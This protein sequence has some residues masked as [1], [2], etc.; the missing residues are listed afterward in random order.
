MY[1]S[2]FSIHW[3]EF[4]VSPCGLVIFSR[5]AACRCFTTRLCLELFLRA[6]DRQGLPGGKDS[7]NV[8][9]DWPR[10]FRF[11]SAHRIPAWTLGYFCPHAAV[12]ENLQQHRMAYPA[13]DDVGFPGPFIQGI[14]AALHLGDHPAGY[15]PVID[16]AGN[17]GQ[18]YAADE[19][20]VLP[21]DPGYIGQ[22]HQ[23]FG[24]ESSRNFACNQVG[25]DVVTLPVHAHP[26][27]G[28]DRQELAVLQGL[29]QL[30]VHLDHI[31]YEADVDH[32]NAAVVVFYLLQHLFAE[33]K[34]AVLA[35]KPDCPAAMLVQVA[36]HL[37]VD[38]TGQHHLDYGHGL[39]VRNPPPPDELGNDA[40]ALQGLVYLRTPAVDHD[41]VDAERAEQHHIES[42]RLLQR[43]IGHGVPAVLDDD[44]LAGESPD[45]RECLHQR[46][47]L[48]D[49]LLH[50]LPQ[51]LKYDGKVHDYSKKMQIINAGEGFREDL[52]QI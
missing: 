11:A 37:L 15:R 16:Q 8:S 45:V 46:V 39:L 40:V 43:F 42:K 41:H 3:A 51:I 20:V 6:P 7:N 38:L 21:L 50:E 52:M 25:I 33:K 32:L 22:E 35:G 48:V 1:L 18:R 47:R 44:G 26:D 30:L 29:D 31:A 36:D 28:D 2:D 17:L 23:L 5:D 24:L 34:V 9:R 12:G 13:I 10:P 27:R 19:S 4:I 49:I 14:Y